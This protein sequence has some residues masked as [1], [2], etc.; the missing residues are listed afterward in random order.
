[1][2]PRLFAANTVY[3]GSGGITSLTDAISCTVVEERNGPFEL[4]MVVSTTTPYF[5]QIEL[6]CLIM[7]KANHSQDPQIFE[8]YEISKPIN[9]QVVI[10]AQHITYRTSFI[11]VTPF[12]AT[13]IT[14]TLLQMAVH[15]TESDP[16]ALTSDITNET[17]NYNQT[18]PGSLRS[19]LGGTEGSL[20]DVFGGEY[21]WDNFTISLLKERGADNG[22]QLRLAKNITDL[23]QTLNVE[24][25]VTGALPY[26]VSEDGM[27]TLFGNTQYSQSVG[28]YAYNRTV[29]L[30]V[31][32]Q[33]ENTPSTSQLDNAAQQY[34][35]K[36]SLASPTNNITVK[37]VDLADTTEYSNSPLERVNL[38]DT[39]EIVY[40]ALGIS[41]KEKAVKLTFDSLAERTLE[42]EVGDARSS[43]SET[44]SDLVGDSAAVI[45]IGKKLVSVTQMIDREIGSI[46]S[47]VATVEEQSD[48]NAQSIVS[49]SSTLEQT[50]N[51][52]RL[53]IDELVQ[54]VDENTT[55]VNNVNTNITF[56]NTGITIGRSDSNIRGVF[57]NT[58][59]DFIDQSDKKVAWLDADDG[60]GASGI[61]LG[62]PSD[63]SKRW[64]IV[65]NET[66]DH[67][68]FIRRF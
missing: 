62:D 7:A 67:L 40:P 57:S 29:L 4:E 13:G 24:R 18:V 64:E 27:T 61:S 14:Q 16:F 28:D 49:L 34:L 31:S 60:L 33:F 15:E 5:D 23:D 56:G 58:S 54:Q 22:V 47:R 66:A 21:L 44:I 53:D 59:L 32:E 45:T 10:R 3:F 25:V 38:C 51:G 11:P 2:I 12:S 63:S 19:R 41:F 43:M 26:W 6:G 46:K 35:L 42:I 52:L 37:F 39:V 68:Y 50:A 17:S 1:M 48:E 30:D 36:A 9:Q 8:I 65:P 20:L 55:T